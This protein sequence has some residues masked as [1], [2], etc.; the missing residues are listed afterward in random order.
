MKLSECSYS[1][2]VWYVMDSEIM[3]F[4]WRA[5]RLSSESSDW[6]LYLMGGEI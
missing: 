2:M 5:G 1:Y 4:N 3:E 6:K